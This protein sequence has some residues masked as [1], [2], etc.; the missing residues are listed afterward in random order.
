M[1]HLSLQDHTITLHTLKPLVSLGVPESSPPRHKTKQN[2]HEKSLLLKSWRKTKKKTQIHTTWSVMKH[3]QTDP[4]DQKTTKVYG[5]DTNYT[6]TRNKYEIIEIWNKYEISETLYCPVNI[7]QYTS[8]SGI[9]RQHP[10]SS[11]RILDARR[12]VRVCVSVCVCVCV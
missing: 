4:K 2:V 1:T 5:I 3:G 11:V 9:I 7:C 8:S 12:P 10:S 6:M